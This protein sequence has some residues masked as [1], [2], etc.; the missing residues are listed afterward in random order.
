MVIQSIAKM[1]KANLGLLLTEKIKIPYLLM[2]PILFSGCLSKTK[3][4]EEVASTETIQPNLLIVFPDQMRGQAMGFMG[5]EPI[6]TPNIDRF[7]KE[8]LVLTDAVSNFPICSPA[9]ASLMSGK[10][11]FGHSVIQNNNSYSSHYGYELA[12]SE[13]CW[14]DIL[15]ERG[16]SLGYIG[17][18]H[19]DNPY[20]PYIKSSNNEGDKKWNEWTPPE[21]RH[22]FDYWYAYG[23]YDDHLKPM[24]WTTDAGRH[25]FHYVNEWG[26]K[27]EADKAI[28]YLKNEKG[29]RMDNE[30]FALVVSNNPPHGPYSKVPEKYKKMYQDIPMDR[31]T[32]RPN[33]P[34][35]GTKHG[36]YY[37]QHIKDYYAMISG[38][39][40]QFGRILQALE[41]TS[42]AKNTIVL[43]LSDHGNCLGIHNVISKDYHY[44]E[45][46]NIPFIMRWPEKI[47]P[48]KDN[49][50]ISMPDIYPTLMEIMGFKNDIPKDIEGV[51]YAA[52]F[53]YGKG[54]RPESQLYMYT[55]YGGLDMGRRGIRTNQYTMMM[56]RWKGKPDELELFDNMNDPYQ[57]NNIG[58][59]DTVTVNLLTQKL[60]SLLEKYNDPWMKH[61]QS[62][63]VRNGY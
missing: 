54:K 42:L 28:A 34:Q 17:K 26:P 53:L 35:K 45:S 55:P 47:K 43:F 2:I 13:K 15:K 27:V 31:L 46:F 11:P 40:D 41:D 20:A 63:K 5:Q 30:P 4:E 39:D 22:G 36:D 10:Y 19:L 38:V 7:A 59:S 51:S 48:K 9:R 61:L 1:N 8:S 49:L 6:K 29:E 52:N 56:S 33:I 50:L 16:Y 32:Q 24:Y 12:A 21:K 57:L 3:K 44:E 14:S 18:W 58:L 25:D 23:T 62:D 37:R 60:K